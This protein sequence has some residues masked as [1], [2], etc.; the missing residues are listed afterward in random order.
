MKIRN[1][2]IIALALVFLVCCNGILFVVM[3]SSNSNSYHPPQ[4]LSRGTDGGE[5]ELNAPR[6]TRGNIYTNYWVDNFDDWGSIETSDNLN[7][8]SSELKLELDYE[9]I[10]LADDFTT[11]PLDVTKWDEHVSGGTQIS[12]SPVLMAL[13][14]AEAQTSDAYIESDTA[15]PVERIVEWEWNSV[16]EGGLAGYNHEFYVFHTS[17]ESIWITVQGDRRVILEQTAGKTTDPVFT[18]SENSW[19]KMSC[20]ISSA[21]A[22]FTIRNATGV[23]LNTQRLDHQ[24]TGAG[25]L[26]TVFAYNSN[27]VASFD[28]RLDNLRIS[29]GYEDTASLTSVAINLPT[30]KSWDTLG[31]DKYEPSNTQ[32]TIS[33][34]NAVNNQPISGYSNINGLSK[35]L[36]SLDPVLYSSIKLRAIFDGNNKISTPILYHWGLS[37]VAQN[38]WQDTFISASKVSETNNVLISEGV[39]KLEDGKTSGTILSEQIYVAETFLWNSVIIEKTELP[40]TSI[41]FSIIDDYTDT[42]IEVIDS[43]ASVQTMFAIDPIK[44]PILRLQATLKGN[45]TATPELYRWSVNWSANSLPEILEFQTQESVLRTRT[46]QIFIKCS[47]TETEMNELEVEFEYKSPLDGAWGNYYFSD[48]KFHNNYWVINFTPSKSADLGNYTFKIECMDEYGGATS[49][50]YEKCLR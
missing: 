22:V 40:S 29:T 16:L 37:W 11:D 19:Y 39:A 8:S 31:L 17:T 38:V 48:K 12:P 4:D 27:T 7:L 2:V 20:K 25:K 44:H 50:T 6:M 18:I 23:L 9:N 35:D 42:P 34:L 5:V 36:S 24:L 3:P 28:V 13:K 33:L 41:K 1:S 43:Q 14:L 45:T 15:W 47:D 46:I 21:E 26:K 30:G 10:A 32:I 49:E